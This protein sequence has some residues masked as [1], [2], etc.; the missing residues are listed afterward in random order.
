MVS[1][2]VNFN[3]AEA[4]AR[5]GYKGNRTAL[6]RIGTENRYK[7]NVAKRLQA[8]TDEALSGANIT[9]EKVLRDLEVTRA[10]SLAD[11]QY[12]SAA[13]CSE[14]QGKYLKMFTER[15]EH[16]Q[17]I[18]EISDEEL[19]SLIRELAAKS[20]VD[21]GSAITGHGPEN[22]TIPAPAGVQKPH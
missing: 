3:G 15:I 17:D 20:N 22:G 19:V 5:A 11:G 4:A 12:A 18:G 8:L 10:K 6:S 2:E 9:V 13:R 16:V 14:L 7:P 21:L 1:A